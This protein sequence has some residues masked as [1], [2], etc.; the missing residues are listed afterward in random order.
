MSNFIF[1][2]GM[3]YSRN[4]EFTSQYRTHSRQA[5]SVAKVLYIPQAY[6]LRRSFLRKDQVVEECHCSLV[7]DGLLLLSHLRIQ[8]VRRAASR[9]CHSLSLFAFSNPYRHFMALLTQC[10]SRCKTSNSRACNED[11]Q[12]SPGLWLILNSH[13]L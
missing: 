4:Y 1:P 13:F 5:L 2:L 9:H 11:F 7:P 10:N 6:R 3:L 8:I 12:G